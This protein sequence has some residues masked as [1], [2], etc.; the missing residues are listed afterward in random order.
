MN[1]LTRHGLTYL[2]HLVRAH[3]NALRLLG[4]ACSLFIHGLFPSSFEYTASDIV[5]WLSSRMAQPHRSVALVRFNRK[6]RE[7][8]FHRRWRVNFEG[9]EYLASSV[10]IRCPSET[11]NEPVVVGDDEKYHVKAAGRLYHGP[12]SSVEIE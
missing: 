11:S 10:K 1:H 9:V 8:K 4:A 6:W 7:D 12:G 2:Q 3:T 5:R